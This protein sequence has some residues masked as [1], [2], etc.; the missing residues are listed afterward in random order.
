MEAMQVAHGSTD[1]ESVSL[2]QVE[3]LGNDSARETVVSAGLSDSSRH[4][5]GLPQELQAP[6]YQSI[7]FMLVHGLLLGWERSQN[8]T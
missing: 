1:P 7:Q 4:L 6:G 2:S 3:N 5:F 8:V